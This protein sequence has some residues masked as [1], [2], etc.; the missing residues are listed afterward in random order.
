MLDGALRTTISDAER[1]VLERDG[2]GLSEG[3]VVESAEWVSVDET[4]A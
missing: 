2:A 3:A 1:E 4:L